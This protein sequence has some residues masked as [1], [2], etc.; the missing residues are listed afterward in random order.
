MEEAPDQPEPEPIQSDTEGL[1]VAEAIPV[2][3]T[4]EQV[5]QV[6]TWV[7]EG[8]STDEIKLAMNDHWPGAD[9]EAIALAVTERLMESSDFT[10][11]VMRGMCV[12]A[13]REVYRRAL[14]MADL[15]VALRAVR[16]LWEMTQAVKI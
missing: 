7:I 4:D 14:E 12:E 8:H 3:P 2:P 5:R 6:L 1:I 16:Q 13:T 15:G 9:G 10:P 11:D